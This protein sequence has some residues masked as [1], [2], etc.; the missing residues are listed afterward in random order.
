M[1]L[2]TN[3]RG[4][5]DPG[6]SNRLPGSGSSSA[7]FAQALLA[8]QVCAP[9]PLGQKNG[10]GIGNIKDMYTYAYI[11]ISILYCMNI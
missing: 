3:Q 8:G 1:F 5:R 7:D 9:K 6:V 4:F 11:Y 10:D 2:T